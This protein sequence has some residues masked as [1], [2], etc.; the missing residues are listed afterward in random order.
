MYGIVH[1]VKVTAILLK[2]L[3][4]PIGGV[5]WGRVCVW[6]LRSRLV[7]VGVQSHFCQWPGFYGKLALDTKIQ[8]VPK[9]ICKH[10][11]FKM[12]KLQ[13]LKEKKKRRHRPRLR[14]RRPRL[15]RRLSELS[16][17]HV[18]TKTWAYSWVLAFSEF[19]FGQK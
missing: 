10:R 4:W 14:I 6:R 18:T 17:R 1:N 11:K 15:K 12:K 7:I 3:I 2:G 5:A 13:Y 19:F 16:F 8:K 9:K